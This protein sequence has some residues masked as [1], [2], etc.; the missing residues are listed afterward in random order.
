MG[1]IK[2]PDFSHQIAVVNKLLDRIVCL[3]EHISQVVLMCLKNDISVLSAL[4]I[5]FVADK[6]PSIIS[7]NPETPEFRIFFQDNRE[8][9][10]AQFD[11]VLLA[12]AVK[13]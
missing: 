4:V 12:F 7:R 3:I 1:T 11:V 5:D 9:K 2:I 13:Y 10:W 6:L 8:C